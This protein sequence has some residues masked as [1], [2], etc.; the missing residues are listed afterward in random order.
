MDTHVVDWPRWAIERGGGSRCRKT[1]STDSCSASP[2]FVFIRFLFFVC[3]FT[4]WLSGLTMTLFD[5]IKK[6]DVHRCISLFVVLLFSFFSFVFRHCSFVFFIF[7]SF[8]CVPVFDFTRNVQWACP[9]HVTSLR[10]FLFAR[11]GI[12][13]WCIVATCSSA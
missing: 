4:S 10:G 7:F 12:C 13:H 5:W 9:L 6:T 8:V 2:H 3:S 11:C 1:R